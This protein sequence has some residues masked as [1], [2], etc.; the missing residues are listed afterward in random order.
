VSTKP[1]PRF[2]WAKREVIE[3]SRIKTFMTK[4]EYEAAGRPVQYDKPG[5]VD[6]TPRYTVQEQPWEKLEQAANSVTAVSAPELFPTPPVVLDLMMDRIDID[7]LPSS[8]WKDGRHRVDFLEPSAGT[9]AIVRAAL[10]R[11]TNLVLNVECCELNR[12]LADGL[13]RA[14]YKVVPDGMNEDFLEYKPGPIYGLICANP[15]F[16]REIEHVRHMYECLAPGGQ[17]VSVMS[18]GPFFRDRDAGFRSWLAA[19]GGTSEKLPE[20][21]F[22][23][24]TGVNTRLIVIRKE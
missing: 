7:T 11:W 21:V 5:P 3:V 24:A 14:G 23:P 17:M 2:S 12:A 10:A 6:E 8:P 18:E 16:S 20:G 19:V 9:G 13:L 4:A 15:P 1:H 22:Q